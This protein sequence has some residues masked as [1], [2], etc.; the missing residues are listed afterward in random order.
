MEHFCHYD[1]QRTNEQHPVFL[2]Q[3]TGY[4][5]TFCHHMACYGQVGTTFCHRMT[6]HGRVYDVLGASGKHFVRRMAKWVVIT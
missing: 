3:P 6:F 4:W 1:V 2:G 5:E